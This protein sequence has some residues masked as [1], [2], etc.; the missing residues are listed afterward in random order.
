[1]TTTVTSQTDVETKPYV[2]SDGSTVN[3]SGEAFFRDQ[4]PI[5][6]PPPIDTLKTSNEDNS[7]ETG[8]NDK[9]KKG[10]II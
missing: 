4:K 1:M 9:T 2:L 7:K 3:F 5:I 10:P 6:P 8:S